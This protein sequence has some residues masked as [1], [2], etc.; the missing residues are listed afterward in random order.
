MDRCP[1]FMKTQEAFGRKVRVQE[2]AETTI[3]ISVLSAPEP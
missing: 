1:D 3:D 2:S